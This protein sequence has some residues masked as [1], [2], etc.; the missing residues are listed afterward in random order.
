MS[1]WLLTK[2][3]RKEINVDFNRLTIWVLHADKTPPHIGISIENKFFS[4]KSNGK[5]EGLPMALLFQLIHAKQLPTLGI[6][7]KNTVTLK[8]VEQV[9][10]TFGSKIGAHET[11]LTP[12]VQLLTPSSTDLILIELLNELESQ[13]LITNVLEYFLPEGYTGIPYYTRETIQ[14]RIHELQPVKR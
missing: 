11:C 13:S 10:G 5:D 2:Y 14:H 6:V 1:E 7:L 12:I 3:G 4:L 9:F 8:E